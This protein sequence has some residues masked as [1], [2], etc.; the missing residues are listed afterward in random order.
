MAA[1]GSL[2]AAR[3]GSVAGP[4]AAPPPLEV[5]PTARTGVRRDALLRR[6]LAL[7]DLGAATFASLL[8]IGAPDRWDGFELAVLA[9]LPTW[10]VVAKLCGLYDRDQ[11]ELRH[12]T[13]DDVTKLLVW[14]V[15]SVAG[16]AVFVPIA[17]G[18]E[19]TMGEGA[20]C[21]LV[22]AAISF[23][24]R[25]LARFAWRRATPPQ[26]IGI[27]GDGREGAAVH[28]K[29]ELFADIHA[30]VVH[31]RPSL[32]AE[33][34]DRRPSWLEGVD[35]VVVVSS[36][37]ADDVV[38]RLVALGRRKHVKVSVIPSVAGMFGTAVQLNHVA[39]MPVVEYNTWDV[40]RSTMLLKRAM[41]VTLS[42]ALLIVLAP[43]MAS[44]AF[45]IKVDGPGPVVFRQ[46][47]AGRDGRPF[48]MLK[49]RTMVVDAEARLPELV[50][51]ETLAEPV[52]KLERDP[53]VTRVGR[54]LR[55]WS[56]DELPQLVNV[57]R[58]EMS[59]VG[60]RPEQLELV[61]RYSPEYFERLRVKPGMT[62]P[63]Q[64]YGR[65]QLSLDER[66][67]V[68]REYIENLTIGRDLRILVLTFPAVLT[69]RG[70]Y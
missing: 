28:R 59:L 37:V 44:I 4:I 67:A 49:F 31:E 17:V 2:P 10:I 50:S 11:R 60:P 26:R 6:L 64:V 52:F 65:G 53:R 29:L 22:A 36:A 55:R 1:H 38:R 33:E 23:L 18:S 20:R 70:A 8:L 45:L 19:L 35:R 47:R 39:D 57:L 42:V 7:A 15:A 61:E 5:S 27:V 68:E 58:G 46:C 25:A 34:L 69:R 16:L 51:I 66:L 40:P 43:V 9:Y 54:V 41:D 32:T 63:M 56:L 62:G 14:S 13:V 3:D 12:L 21:A 24:L 30:I 48:S